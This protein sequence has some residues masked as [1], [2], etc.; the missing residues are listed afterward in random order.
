MAKMTGARCRL[1]RREGTRLFLKGSRCLSPKCA[2]VRKNY[3]PG[4]QGA[5]GKGHRLSEYGLHLREKQKVRRIYGI[6]ERQ[7]RRYYTQASIGKGITGDA[8][9]C[10]LESRL[11]NVIFRAGFAASRVQARQLVS[12]GFFKVN[13]KKVNLP[14]YSVK[15]KEKI[16]LVTKASQNKYF[17]ALNFSPSIAFSWLNVDQ[18][19]KEIEILRAPT[20]QD[21]DHTV[22][23]SLIVEFYSR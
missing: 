17:Q 5:K 16:T 8:L 1:C 3:T 20:R 23:M 2:I 12:H 15:P 7:F 21:I 14:S 13:G 9:F 22:D 11:D 4:R 6:L 18:K 19:L 10:I